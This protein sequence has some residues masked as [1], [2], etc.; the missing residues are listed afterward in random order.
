MTSGKR[1]LAGAV[2]SLG[3]VAAVLPRPAHDA[4]TL[5]LLV[6]AALVLVPLALDLI[7]ERNDAGQVAGWLRWAQ[8]FQFWAAASL[9]FACYLPAGALAAVFALPWLGVTL[10][11]AAI[12]IVRVMRHGAARP[13]D[14]LCA[15]AALVF[16]AIG[17]LWTVADRVG[18]GPLKFD[19]AIVALTAVHFH[20]A[21]L[22]L[23]LCT[24][25]VARRMPA[26]RFVGRVT[27]GVV[28]GVPAVALG[29]T[30]T[31]LGWGPA[32]EAAA[33]VG[34]A[35]AAACVAI[36]HVRQAL[37]PALPKNARV[38]LG[39]AGVSL[40]FGMVLAALYALRGYAAPIDGLGVPQMRAL[41]GTVNALGF[42]LC[43]VLGWRAATK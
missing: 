28:L 17:G 26:S 19:R 18:Y 1:A 40:F 30:A 37:E 32:F 10:L 24:G 33:G 29:I 39:I 22:L 3:F 21:G 6:F 8:S 20:Y 36:C 14:R 12:G 2:V 7:I 38:L 16:L 27:V 13:L 41:H 9:A 5:A 42:G 34:L 25:L 11:L 31:Q 4:W 23:P 35:L 43:G 15:D